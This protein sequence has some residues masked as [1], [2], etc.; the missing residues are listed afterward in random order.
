[1]SHYG[2]EQTNQ[3][4]FRELGCEET[5]ISDLELFEENVS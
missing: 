4:G 3:L 5:H 2:K 1:M